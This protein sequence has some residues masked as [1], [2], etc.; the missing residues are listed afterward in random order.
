MSTHVVVNTY[1]HSV[2]YV[3]NKMLTSLKEI[4]R[5]SG[6]SPA[7]FVEDWKVLHDGI[8][9]WIQSRDLEAVIL[10][11]FNPRTDKLIGRWDFDIFYGWTGDGGMYVD[12]DEIKYHILKAGQWPSACEYRIVVTT[13]KGRPDVV[14]WS[15]ATLRSTDGFVRQS[16]GTTIDGSGLKSG[17]RILESSEVITV[18]DAFKKFRSRLELTDRSKRTRPNVTM[19]FAITSGPSS[20]SNAIS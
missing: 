7:K 4:I 3:T 1:T 6:L 16:L 12:T 8:S 9:T 11:V 20:R 5:C 19:K 17:N 14:G 2:T 18:A 15:G 10:E 13:K